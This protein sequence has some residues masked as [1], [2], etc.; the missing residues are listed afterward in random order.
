MVLRQLPQHGGQAGVVRSGAHDAHSKDGVVSNF[1][2]AVRET[3]NQYSM[4][5]CVRVYM[6]ACVYVCVCI[7]V[8]VYVCACVR[9]SVCLRIPTSPKN[10]FHHTNLSWENLE[11]VS[12]MLSFG[13]EGE[14]RA[15][16]NGTDRRIVN[17]P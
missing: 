16:A 17:S 15:N 11:S 5:I 12:R 2:V 10:D 3:K 7:C 8:R 13:L 14:R 1:R 4:C 6:C 9:L